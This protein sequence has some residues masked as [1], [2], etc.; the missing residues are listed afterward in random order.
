M[1]RRE[2]MNILNNVPEVAYVR[3][4]RNFFGDR[5]RTESMDNLNN[6]PEAEDG[7]GVSFRGPLTGV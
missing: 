3:F 2:K 7:A 6:V 1:R 4:D 5:Q